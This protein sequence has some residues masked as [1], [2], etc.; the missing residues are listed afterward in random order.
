MRWCWLALI[1]G[2]SLPHRLESCVPDMWA[3]CFTASSF[4]WLGSMFHRLTAI[5]APQNR[6]F[7]GSWFCFLN[8]WM[9][10]FIGASAYILCFMWNW[11]IDPLMCCCTLTCWSIC[12]H[13]AIN[14]KFEWLPFPSF[15]VIHASMHWVVD[16][17]HRLNCTFF[18]LPT[19]C[20]ESLIHKSTTP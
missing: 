6:W 10:C 1:R 19:C 2:F 17:L 5:S 14:S 15:E 16:S 20:F 11:H 7:I 12:N 4:G 3:H 9:C 18:H 13:C 8:S